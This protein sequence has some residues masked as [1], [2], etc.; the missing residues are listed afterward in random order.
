MMRLLAICL[1]LASIALP[2]GRP[3]LTAEER[4]ADFDQMWTFVRDR[5]A[6]L[7]EKGY[8]RDNGARPLAR[9]IQ[10]EVKRPLS[11]ELLFGELERG[12]HVK[13][14]M[15]GG[16]LSFEMTAAETVH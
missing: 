7:A 5:Y 16:Q 12:G 4:A 14:V 10:D 11:N 1:L 9:V 2:Q 13:L 15:R 3:Q 6:Y 8:D